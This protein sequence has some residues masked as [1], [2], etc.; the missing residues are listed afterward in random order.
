MQ[1]AYLTS[2]LCVC[3]CISQPVIFHHQ[4]FQTN[5]S[6]QLLFLFI[7]SIRSCE[8]PW[9]MLMLCIPPY[10]NIFFV[11]F[12]VLNNKTIPSHPGPIY[13]WC[14]CKCNLY[15]SCLQYIRDN[16]PSDNK[17]V[18]SDAVEAD[19]KATATDQINIDTVNEMITFTGNC[20]F[21]NNPIKSFPTLHQQVQP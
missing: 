9:I 7:N 15:F 16:K 11:D 5:K 19:K 4:T 14:V 10:A 8:N 3:V 17:S 1:L 12:M 6:C 20:E 21:C 18:T 13:R 2:W